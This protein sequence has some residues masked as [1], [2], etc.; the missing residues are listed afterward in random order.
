LFEFLIANQK[1]ADLKGF[2]TDFMHII[3][4]H[5]LA[6]IRGGIDGWESMVPPEV[7][8][9]IIDGCLFGYPCDL[10]EKRKQAEAFLQQQPDLILQKNANKETDKEPAK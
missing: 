1:I 7:S 4:D 5:V 2:R 6:M 3:S 8:K 9:K 10:M